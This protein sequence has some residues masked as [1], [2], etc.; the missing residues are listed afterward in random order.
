[1]DMPFMNKAMDWMPGCRE[2]DAFVVDY[3]EGR[4]PWRQRLTFRM[5]LGMCPKCR[6]YL[7]A[8]AKTLELSRTAYATTPEPPEMPEELVQV[9]LA[10]WEER[11]G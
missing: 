10:V 11:S 5:H 9:I 6:A 2:L 4:L 3:L 8:Y 7:K 1:M